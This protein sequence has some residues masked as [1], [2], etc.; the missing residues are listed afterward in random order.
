MTIKGYDVAS[1]QSSTFSLSGISF[2]IVKAT[3]STNYVNPKMVAQ[4]AHARAAGLHVGYYHFVRSGDM[5]K[6][7]DYF[8]SK[9]T[10]VAGDSLWLDWEDDKV[11]SAQKDAFLKELKRQRP[12]HKVGLYC[13]QNFWL[14]RDKSS[15]VEDGLWLA[16]YTGVP[17]KTGIQADWLIHQYNNHDTSNGAKIDVNVA[18]F[19]SLAKMKAWAKEDLV[20]ATPK[21]TT[22]TPTTPKPTVPKPVPVALQAVKVISVAKGEVDYK[23]GAGNKN[24]FSTSMGRPAEAWC[25]D[26]VSWVA[27]T[28]G[29][30]SLYPN[31]ASCGVGLNWFRNKKRTSSYPA[32]GAQ[33]FY[34]NST[35]TY[36]Y[37][38]CHT[39]I[40]WKYDANYIYTIGGNTNN[41]GAS[42]GDGVYLRKVSRSSSWTHAYGY[43]LFKEGITTADPSKKGKK[44]FTYLAVADAPAGAPKPVAR[45][46]IWAENVRYGKVNNSIAIVQKALIKEFGAFGT[47]TGAFGPK[48]KAAYIKWQKKLGYTGSDADGVPGNASLA[49]LAKKYGFDIKHK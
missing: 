40:V 42:N 31:T 32:I 36:G 9:A 11:T 22:P 35:C 20:P 41:T 14:T 33:V 44:G 45:P 25:A 13:S 37:G 24:K 34:G 3:E 8:L 16:N 30:A 46:W 5:K 10:E 49:A 48:T 15:F 39:E 29:V 27:K 6:Q 19:A 1:Y 12:T 23:E 38:G 43:P 18:D 2:V 47:A 26:F 21:P 4:V 17:G 28:A 7:V